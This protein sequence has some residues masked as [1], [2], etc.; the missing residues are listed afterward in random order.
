MSPLPK[1]VKGAIFSCPPK[2]PPLV[3]SVFSAQ[4]KYIQLKYFPQAI[5]YRNCKPFSWRRYFIR[6]STAV[7]LL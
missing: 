6:H 1:D 3:R 2:S 5:S 7:T 4:K